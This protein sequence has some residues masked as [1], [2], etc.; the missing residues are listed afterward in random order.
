[1]TS[2]V[3]PTNGSGFD[4]KMTDPQ[5]EKELTATAPPGSFSC[6]CLNVQLFTSGPPDKTAIVADEDVDTGLANLYAL[7]TAEDNL[8][9]VSHTS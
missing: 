7:S 2:S 3:L 4:G 5:V 9:V 1:M 8:Q 6:L